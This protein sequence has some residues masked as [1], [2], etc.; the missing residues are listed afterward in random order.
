MVSA[1]FGDVRFLTVTDVNGAYRLSGVAEGTWVLSIEMSGFTPIR[2]EIRVGSDTGPLV[3]ALKI[4]PLSETAGVA[5]GAA[6][7]SSTP[8]PSDRAEGN[9]SGYRRL[10]VSPAQPTPTP[11]AGEAPSET[12]AMTADGFL[13]N[14]SVNNAAA[15]RFVQSS[16]FGNN[17]RRTASSYNGSLAIMGRHAA[18]DARPVS[19]SGQTLP[20]EH[21]R[22]IQWLG[23][24]GGPLRWDHKESHGTFFLGLERAS[25]TQVNGISA[26][27]P[28]ARE[29][30]GDFSR[31]LDAS[32]RP[33]DIRDPTSG[34][35]FPGAVVPTNRISAEAAAL[36]QL[37]PQPNV[38]APGRSN[39]VAPVA[40]SFRQHS[41]QSRVTWRLDASNQVLG[42]VAFQRASG[43]GRTL[44][45]FED[46]GHDSGVDASAHWLH[47]YSPR[48]SMRLGYR[49]TRQSSRVTPFFAHR[50][51]VSGD[52]GL[53]GSD[54]T[55]ENWGPP[56]LTFASGLASLQDA[57][58]SRT[59][60]EGNEGTIE[61]YVSRGR[62]NLILG[63]E[64]RALRVGL[65]GSIN[66]RGSLTFSGA[67]TGWDVADFLLG[68]PQTAAVSYGDSDRVLHGMTGAAY[69]TDDFRVGPGLTL[70]LGVRWDYESPLT[71]RL[72]RLVNL[73]VAPQFT[74]VAPVLAT[75]GRGA[76]TGRDYPRALV[77]SDYGVLQPRVA[78]TWRPMAGSSL[79]IR[80]GYGIYRDAMVYSPV[81]RLLAQQPPLVI[82]SNAE[83]SSTPELTLATAFASASHF[84]MPLFGV[85]RTF[86]GGRA[87]AW[88]LAVQRDLPQSLVLSLSY[89]GARASRLPRQ[90]LPNT[91]PPGAARGCVDCPAGFVFLESN[92]RAW[93][94]AATI[95]VRRRLHNGISGSL[96]YTWANARDN[97]AAVR[98]ADSPTAVQRMTMLMASPDHAALGLTGA[99][100]AQNWLDLDAELGP[101]QFDQRHLLQARFDYTT[102]AG[103][104][105]ASGGI[106]DL[107]W[108]DWTA[109]GEFTAG[110]GFPFTPIA[111]IAIPST[112]MTGMRADYLG[113]GGA[114][115]PGAYVNPASYA[116]PSDGSWGNAGRHSVR[117]PARYRLDASLVRSFRS[118][119]RVSMEFRLDATNVLNHVTY[120]NVNVTVGSPQFGYPTLVDPMRKLQA[121]MRV[122]F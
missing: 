77:D 31:T 13:I 80:S 115:P 68:L 22:D 89:L 122:R 83:R 7:P 43:D 99:P 81:A 105:R 11:P 69:V 110:S 17:R 26:I 60:D 23:A 86:T 40:T 65:H 112:T 36:L 18:L 32:G 9:T 98:P 119:E 93:R 108:R 20:R 57:L 64:L 111:L 120:A 19:A 45:G 34:T 103:R 118:T 114:M 24:L 33:I 91:A 16:A 6:S 37:Y 97:G 42:A 25:D 5:A 100:I 107:I 61:A 35:L 48:T 121:S 84:G 28:T 82:S 46:E 66:P 1:A 73:D 67:A 106:T 96:Q 70:N 51:N 27:V 75:D 8:P 74:A 10:D 62:H 85:D 2:R 92:G 88:Q 56:T 95:Q 71:E 78:A 76:I 4:A 63:G 49:L 113:P 47:R 87:H 79:V 59:L 29:R 109:G 90:S 50:Q 55:S 30:A 54:Q 14:G 101:S 102:A 15:S 12:S 58:A 41:L 52:A 21:Y 44:F 39:L 117:G 38:G 104:R 94:D 53:L 72:D 3:D 116:A